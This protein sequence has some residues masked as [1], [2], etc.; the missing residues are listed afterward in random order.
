MTGRERLLACLRGQIP[1]RVPISTYE[2]VPWNEEDWASREPS[3][4]RLMDVI[5]RET[6]G[7]YMVG[8]PLRNR[9]ERKSVRTWREG[10][11]A[12]RETTLHTPRG[13]LRAV[14]AEKDGIHTVWCLDH[15]LKDDADIDRWLSQPFDL[16][17]PDPAGIRVARERLGV[18][19]IP[20]VSVDD[21]ICLA[22]ELFEFGEFTVQATTN[23]ARI[24]RLLD[25]IHEQQMA[26]LR[27]ILGGGV[28]ETLFRI[29][30]P[31]YA[32]PPHLPPHLFD[33]LVAPYLRRIVAA[34]H[35]AGAFARVHSHGRIAKVLD[36][37]AAAEPDALDPLEPPPDG[38]LSLADAKRRVG[39]RMALMG[40]IEL[41]WLEGLSS[42][43]LERR[44]RQT[45][46]DGK[47]GGR[48][49]IMPTAAPINVPL[50]PRTEENYI[51]F[52]ETALGCG[53][54]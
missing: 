45:M 24:R 9:A 44:V 2:L 6:D 26:H 48:F 22:A 54:Y 11:T 38:D 33:I 5:R 16:E 43:E 37:I 4:R 19:G 23:L 52:I 40:N 46:E 51:R 41:H 28:E 3:Y 39:H 34:I 32:T 30:G 36:A 17:P 50:S 14:H 1:D 15:F 21:P 18:A 42:D 49:V 53:G 7:L 8:I 20:L 13:D 12:Y 35:E 10:D 29:C 31:E 27:A 25:A 47:P